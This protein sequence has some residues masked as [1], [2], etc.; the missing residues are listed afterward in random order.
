M[1]KADII[2]A[3]NLSIGYENSLV[4]KDANFSIQKGQFVGILGP[5]GSGKTTLFRLLLGL[6]QP[7]KG[8][9]SIF[10]AKPKRGNSRIGYVPQRHQIDSE[11]AI[12]TLEIVKLGAYPGTC[13]FNSLSHSKRECIDALH[14]LSDVDA[15]EF[16]HK[17]LGSLSGGEQQ[18][19]FLAQ[20]ISGNPELLLL[21]EPLA[22]LDIRREGELV[23]LI[24]RVVKTRG[25]TVLLTAHNINPLLTVLD[26]LM[27]IANGHVAT[28]NPGDVLNS[29]SLSKLYNAPIEVLHDSKGRIAIVGTEEGAH[30]H[31][32]D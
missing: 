22:N 31:D 29:E 1:E 32:Y 11:I 27:Y 8:N 13:G 19:I 24:H 23:K 3:V 26:R 18:R 10:G 7:L 14:A 16:A 25:I 21:D 28:G 5:N 6:L 12:E 15:L 2:T 9:L 30:H 17:P 20:A 4:W